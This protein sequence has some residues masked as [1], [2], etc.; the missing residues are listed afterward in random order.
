[1]EPAQHPLHLINPL[2]S[3][4][5]SDKWFLTFDV[6]FVTDVILEDTLTLLS[7][8]D[9]RSTFFLTGP[10]SLLEGVRHNR[11]IDLGI[12]PNFNPLLQG[13]NEKS[14]GAKAIVKRL[15]QIVPEALSVRSH[16]L[17]QSSRVHHLFAEAGLTHDLNTFVPA[18][19]GNVVAPWTDW[20]GLV[21]VP[22][23]WED[24]HFCLSTES[25]TPEPSPIE[26]VQK[27]SGFSVINFHPIHVYLNT[28]SL[29]RY[30]AT[31]SIH[32]DA[33]RLKDFRF[34]GYGTRNRLLDLLGSTV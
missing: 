30:E 21:R 3:E 28:E 9:V 24:D 11:N 8:F 29:K 19:S 27:Q 26:L 7:D 5:W 17:A 34:K 31:R 15:L 14:G 12:H 32:Q 6:D 33:E 16:S 13:G 2:K 23:Q 4:S 1:M 22:F 20:N 18:G 25:A 10:T